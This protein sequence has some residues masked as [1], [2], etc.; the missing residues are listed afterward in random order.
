MKTIEETYRE[1]LQLLINEYGS[2]QA[3]SDAIGKS[4]AQISQWLNGSP[5]S[6]T[7]KPRSLKSDTAREIEQK[8]GKPR[9]WFDQPL[10]SI[11][12]VENGYLVPDGYIKFAVMDAPAHMGTGV[13]SNNE[14]IEI[15]NFVAVAETWAKKHLGGS[16]S[17]IQVITGIGDSMAGTIEAGEILFIDTSINFYDGEGIYVIY[18]PNGR[19]AKRLQTLQNGNLKIISDN[20]KYDTEIIDKNDLDQIH[21]FGKLKGSWGFKNFD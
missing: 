15:V 6:K 12:E 11:I 2:Q 1:R 16:L 10:E 14:Y 4:A 13:E 21:I 18:T 9:A 19:R 20:K 3:L 8:L 7:G 5:D 17:K